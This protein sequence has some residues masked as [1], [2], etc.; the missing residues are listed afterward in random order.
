MKFHFSK[1]LASAVIGAV[2]VVVNSALDNPISDDQVIMIVGVIVAYLVSQGIADHGSQG[3][4]TAAKR[5]IEQGGKIADVVTDVL[6]SRKGLPVSS[7]PGVH[8]DEDD[9][10]LPGWVDASEMEDEDKPK[11]LNG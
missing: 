2:V 9:T 4:A 3:A 8:D 11:C 7:V 5:A 6:A 1:K 10:D